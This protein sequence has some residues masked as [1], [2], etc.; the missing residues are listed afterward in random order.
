MAK[1]IGYERADFTAKETGGTITG[2][3]VWLS[4][5]IDPKRGKGVAVDKYYMTDAKINAARME[6]LAALLGKEAEVYFNRY[7]KVERIVA[8]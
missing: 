8:R 6:D 2:Y 3:N 5:E 7:G 1:L 4:R